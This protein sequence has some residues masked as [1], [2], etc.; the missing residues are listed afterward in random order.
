MILEKIQY[1]LIYKL[2]KTKQFKSGRGY[3]YRA[4]QIIGITV[5]LATTLIILTFSNFDVSKSI[6]LAIFLA[7]G[8]IFFLML[9]I[10]TSRSKLLRNRFIY[11]ICSKY[12]SPYFLVIFSIILGLI[13]LEYLTRSRYKSTFPSFYA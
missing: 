11:P 10:N 1:A 9:E 12:L 8:S 3:I 7:F 2:Y 13:L 4:N 5:A 6:T